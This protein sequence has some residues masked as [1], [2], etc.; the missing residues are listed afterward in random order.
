MENNHSTDMNKIDEAKHHQYEVWPSRL[1][2]IHFHG[3]QKFPYANTNFS[4][5]ARD[6][7][8]SQDASCSTSGQIKAVSDKLVND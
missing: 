8:L 6:L 4:S 2:T 7:T 1:Y 3:S 5:S